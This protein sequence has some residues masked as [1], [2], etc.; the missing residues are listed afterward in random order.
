M[1]CPVVCPPKVFLETKRNIDR[2]HAHK[3][4]FKLIHFASP[5]CL[6]RLLL[7]VPLA[8]LESPQWPRRPSLSAAPTSVFVVTRN[9][10]SA[11][12]TEL[13]ATGATLVKG[14]FAD[15]ESLKSAFAGAS[16]AY[17]ITPGAEV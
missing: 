14:D 15:V 11:S 13:A 6:A 4:F 9:L 3:P 12:A 7:L 16:I 1:V 10:E 8:T 5:K 17:I 2:I